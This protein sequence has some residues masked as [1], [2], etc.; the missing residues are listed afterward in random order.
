MQFATRILGAGLAGMGV[1]LS[2]PFA[3]FVVQSLREHDED[4]GEEISGVHPLGG[5]APAFG[6]QLAPAG[7]AGGNAEH[8]RALGRGDFDFGTERGLGQCDGNFYVQIVP[9]R[10]KNGCVPT[11]TVMR[12]SPAVPP[13]EGAGSP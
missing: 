11:W 13:R 8:D 1:D 5:H 9:R 2:D 12:M 6:A 7:S 3:A 10:L 4:F